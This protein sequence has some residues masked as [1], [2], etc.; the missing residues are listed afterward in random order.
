MVPELRKRHRRIWQIGGV[1]LCLGF[2]AAIWVLPK[3]VPAGQWP[4]NELPPFP[5][6]LASKTKGNLSFQLRQGANDLKQIEITQQRV[7][8]QTF[9]QV[10]CNN[11]LQGVLGPAGVRR[12]SLSD[13]L[14]AEPPYLIEL[15]DGINHKT[16]HQIV[17]P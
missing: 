2:A 6:V 9:V 10:F 11:A 16:I 13:T 8:E 3:P 4:G 1:L 12:F 7:M 14:S 15:V 5:K 17:L